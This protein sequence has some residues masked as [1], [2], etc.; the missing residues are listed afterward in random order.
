MSLAEDVKLSAYWEA[1]QSYTFC[2]FPLSFQNKYIVEEP[3]YEGRKHEKSREQASKSP[4]E[5]F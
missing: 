4:T 1:A 2:V 3:Y 5:F